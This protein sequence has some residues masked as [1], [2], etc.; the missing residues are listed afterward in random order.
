[1]TNETTYD[2]ALE[3]AAHARE[4]AGEHYGD[5]GPNAEIHRAFCEG[6]AHADRAVANAEALVV[7][8]APPIVPVE[9]AV[10]SVN[11]DDNDIPF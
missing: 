3:A 1:M 7:D 2:E 4:F 8:L 10:A 9:A 5:H 6:C 11:H